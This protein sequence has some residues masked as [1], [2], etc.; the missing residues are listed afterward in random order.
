MPMSKKV[1][2]PGS[3]DE[4]KWEEAKKKCIKEYGEIKWPVVTTIYKDLHGKFH[5][6]GK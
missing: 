5:N 2:N 3:V 1:A 6:K 4:A